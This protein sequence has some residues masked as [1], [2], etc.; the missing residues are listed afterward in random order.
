MLLKRNLLECTTILSCAGTF[1]CVLLNY[2]TNISPITGIWF[3]LYV[4]TLFIVSLCVSFKFIQWLLRLNKPIKYDLDGIVS[5]YP[6]LSSL[7][8]LLPRPR[9]AVSE[10]REYDTNEL[11]V[12]STVLERKLVS[13]WYVPYISQEIGFPFACK[14]MLD[15]MIGK[16]FQVCGF[17]TIIICNKYL[18]GH[19]T[20]K[21]FLTLFQMNVV[22]YCAS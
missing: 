18:H 7:S 6:Y 10:I 17:D 12:I 13:S 3:P 19:K 21:V 5:D 11:S 20:H 22:L 2:I 4:I 15:Q 16:S 9:K 8:K 1:I 14:Q